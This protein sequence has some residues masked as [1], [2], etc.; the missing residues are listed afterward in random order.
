M[1]NK[2]DL[3][4][5]LYEKKKFFTAVCIRLCVLIANDQ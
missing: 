1:E 5:F 2:I 4:M 3:N